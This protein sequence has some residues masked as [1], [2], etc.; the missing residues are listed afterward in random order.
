MSGRANTP[1]LSAALQEMPHP[2]AKTRSYG[3]I[4]VMERIQPADAGISVA[5]D[6]TP[7]TVALQK[8][9]MGD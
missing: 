6:K 4:R 7:A 2:L 5:T 1:L 8:G 9:M 3:F